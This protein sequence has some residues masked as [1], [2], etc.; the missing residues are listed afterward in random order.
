MAEHHYYL[1]YHFYTV[2]L[3]RHLTQRLPGYDYERDFGGALYLFIRGL[4]PD[5]RGVYFDRPQRALLDALGA[6]LEGDPG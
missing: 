4:G 3:H 2:A 1:Q 6:A 5:G